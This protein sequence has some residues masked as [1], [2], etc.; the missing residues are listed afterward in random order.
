MIVLETDHGRFEAD[1][2]DEALALAR[3]ARREAL[4]LERARAVWHQLADMRAMAHAYRILRE[5]ARDEAPFG[6][7]TRP[8][9]PRGSAVSRESDSLG[10][11]WHRARYETPDGPAQVE[12]HGWLVEGAV[13]DGGGFTVAVF[14][15]NPRTGERGTYAIGVEHDQWAFADLPGVHIEDWAP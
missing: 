8:G 12:H 11:A 4:A 6:F 15:M 7:F 14:L 2:E 9:E 3:K 5:R 13:C 1:T 10:S